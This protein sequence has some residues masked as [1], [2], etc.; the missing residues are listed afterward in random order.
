MWEI[1][2]A[3][4]TRCHVLSLI[5]FRQTLKKSIC[6][7][8]FV[9]TKQ[10]SRPTKNLTFD[11]SPFLPRTHVFFSYHQILKAHNFIRDVRVVMRNQEV[12]IQVER[13]H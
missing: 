13:F 7:V 4:T 10:Q 2:S 6:H 3:C 12:L 8:M 9:M 5:F 1:V 11:I